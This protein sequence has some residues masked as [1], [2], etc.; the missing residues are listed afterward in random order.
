MSGGLGG[1]WDLYRRAEQYGHAMAVVNDYLGEGMRDK[2]MQR[3]QE[4]AGPL[5]RSGWKE[6][7]EMVA[8]ALAAAGVDRATI[9]AL[10]IAYL[11]RSGRLHEKR[12]WTSEPPEV[13]E[14]LRQWRLL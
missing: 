7:W 9:R 12:D 11:K 3:F 10:H 6:P 8:H 5:Q 2:V 1:M 4:L 14:R 13:L